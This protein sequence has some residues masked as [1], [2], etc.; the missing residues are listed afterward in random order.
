MY[1]TKD[2]N[3]DFRTEANSSQYT[4]IKGEKWVEC[5]KYLGTINYNK[6]RFD[7]NTKK[8]SASFCQTFFA[9]L[10]L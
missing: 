4:Y 10:L 1:K 6:L 9:L 7:V 5:Y 8:E 3:I 2:M